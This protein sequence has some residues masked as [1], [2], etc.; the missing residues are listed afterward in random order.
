M[1]DA[2]ITDF[3]DSAITGAVACVFAAYMYFIAQKRAALAVII[4]FTATALAIAL[5]K[6][7]VYSHCAI[8]TGFYNVRSPS[9]HTALS[10]ATYGIIASIISTALPARQKPI[11][12]LILAPIVFFI[13][14]SRVRIGAHTTAEVIAG[15][16]CG[17]GIALAVWYSFIRGQDFRFRW[18]T[19]L[20]IVALIAVLLYGQHLPAENLI[21]KLS[22]Y[23]QK[24]RGCNIAII[25][26]S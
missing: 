19:A 22:V 12:Y 7:A 2:M 3:G 21:H 26:S 20:G 16:I 10:I 15:A 18:Q 8:G 4:A 23:L 14:V 24:T 13:A 1:I 11:P 6:I 25:P 5:Y 17:G 9:G